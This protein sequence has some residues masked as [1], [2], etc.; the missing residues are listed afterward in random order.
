MSFYRYLW[1]LSIKLKIFI[2][3][4]KTV[5]FQSTVSEPIWCENQIWYIIWT[6][7]TVRWNYTYNAKKESTHIHRTRNWK[8]QISVQIRGW[9]L[10]VIYLTFYSLY[11]LCYCLITMYTSSKN[12][13]TYLTAVLIE[14]LKGAVSLME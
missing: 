10:C 13:I 6:A 5:L 1:V 7:L 4:D 11:F 8:L 14:K 2:N 3:K 12:F 9:K